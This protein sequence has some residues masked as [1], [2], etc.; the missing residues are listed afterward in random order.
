MSTKD[1]FLTALLTL[2][3]VAP[4]SA[5]HAATVLQEHSQG[6]VTFV[7]GGV[8]QDEAAAMRQAAADYPLTLEMATAAGGPRDAYIAHAKVDIQDVTGRAVLE[9][10]TDGPLML[11]NLPSGIYHVTVNWN[12][13]EREKTVQVGGDRRQHVML[14][15]PNVPGNN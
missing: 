7:S 4:A 14:E 10:T 15:F 9:T 6:P 5:V 1:R 3:F 12:G 13:V 2:A 8:G 11:V